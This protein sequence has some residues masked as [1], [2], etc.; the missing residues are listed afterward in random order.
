[1]AKKRLLSPQQEKFLYNWKN[2]NSPTFGNAYRSALDA[3]YEEE[4]A[5]TVTAKMPDWLAENVS[6]GMLE[7][8]EAA[9]LEAISLQIR[10]DEGKIDASVARIKADVAKFIAETVGKAKYSKRTEM[11]GKDGGPIEVNSVSELSDD[12]LA[13]LAK[14]S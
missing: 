13:N 11:T 8:A 10:N 2:P 14:S 6:D 3:G 7:K 4:Y 9:L 12:E 1:M 5:K